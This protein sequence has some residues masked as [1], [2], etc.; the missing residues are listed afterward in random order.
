L[1]PGKYLYSIMNCFRFF[2]FQMFIVY[3]EIDGV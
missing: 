3:I 2:V 1:P